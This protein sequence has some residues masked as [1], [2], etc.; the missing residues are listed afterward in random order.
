VRAADIV[1]EIPEVNTLQDA[2]W[3]NWLIHLEDITSSI[4]KLCYV[5]RYRGDPRDVVH[6]TM[7][8]AQERWPEYQ[9]SKAGF[10]TWVIW[11]TRAYLSN[12][13]ATDRLPMM[14]SLDGEEDDTPLLEAIPGE[15]PDVELAMIASDRTQAILSYVMSLDMSGMKVVVLRAMAQLIEDGKKPSSRNIAELVGFSHTTVCKVV[16]EIRKDLE[17]LGVRDVEPDFIDSSVL[18]THF[19]P[20]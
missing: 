6:E 15:S 2:F 9:R 7:M 11:I 16:K 19:Y 3:V 12:L 13:Y 5:K 8:I 17:E 20:V 18:R 1:L 14:Q 10:K 4:F